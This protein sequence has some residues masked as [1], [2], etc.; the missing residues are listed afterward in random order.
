M[1]HYIGKKLYSLLIKKFITE[2]NENTVYRWV[3]FRLFTEYSHFIHIIFVKGKILPLL[4]STMLF[5]IFLF[6][7]NS[8][9]FIKFANVGK[10]THLVKFIIS[11]E[12]IQG[13]NE[14]NTII[15]IMNF[16]LWDSYAV[17][18]SCFIFIALLTSV[19]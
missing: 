2:S 11:C 5:T 1:I 10:C 15:M 14:K 8:G 13:E 12:R 9:T 18:Q 6:S 16:L 4:T 19:F 3:I 7:Y 17:V